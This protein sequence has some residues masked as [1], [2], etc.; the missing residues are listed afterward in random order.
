MVSSSASSRFETEARTGGFYIESR[1]PILTVFVPAE[2]QPGMVR[3][4]GAGFVRGDANLDGEVNLSDAVFTLSHLFGGGE[5]PGCEDSLDA[6]D[7]GVVNLTDAV[8]L[9]GSLFEGGAE[10]PPP[11]PDCGADESADE[12]DCRRERCSE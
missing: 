3:L 1:D 6:D 2:T 5:D 8:F 12:L 7:S 9:L 10:I 4:A 11:H